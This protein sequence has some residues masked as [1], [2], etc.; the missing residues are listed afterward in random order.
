[1]SLLI[2]MI[3]ESSRGLCVGVKDV[4]EGILG[5]FSSP[6]TVLPSSLCKVRSILPEN[7]LEKS[8]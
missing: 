4:L 6:S 8:S 3:L 7:V 5:V 2:A 1:M